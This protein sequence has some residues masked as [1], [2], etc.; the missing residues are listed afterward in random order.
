MAVDRGLQIDLADA[1]EHTDEEG[2]DGDERAGVRGLD[3][4]LAELG[5]EPF[6]EPRL[7]GCE[8]DRA[9]G[10]GPLQPQQ[11][12]MFRQQIVPAPNAAHAARADLEPAQGQLVRD[13]HRAMGRV[14]ERVVEDRLPRS[15]APPG[16]GA[17]LRTLDLVD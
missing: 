7:L 17:D 10:R 6:Q 5:A 13:P 11:A 1:L 9:L 16:S 4:P 15:P 3:V 14:R 8:L 2:V 12:L